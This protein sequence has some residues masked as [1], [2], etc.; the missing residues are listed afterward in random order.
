[1]KTK[2]FA[3][4]SILLIFCFISCSNVLEEKEEISSGT[5]TV[6]FNFGNERAIVSTA[7]PENY[8]Y[9]LKGTYANETKTLCEKMSYTDFLAKS[10][11][12]SQG[13]WAFGIT[14]YKGNT[15]VYSDTQN[16]AVSLATNTISFTLRAITGGYGSVSV[17]LNYPSNKGVSKVT[18]AF[19]DDITVTDTGDIL[20]LA[21]DSSAT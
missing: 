14:A 15:A 11:Y 4:I 7:E 8:F 3:I 2:I 21:S 6:S 9:T 16:V 1:M 12:I 5:A 13:D 20:P 19:Y 10:F 18:A 17:K